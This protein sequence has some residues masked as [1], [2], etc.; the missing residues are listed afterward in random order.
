MVAMLASSVID[1][2]FKLLSGQTKDYIIDNSLSM[3]Q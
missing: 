3:Q 2:G 1:C